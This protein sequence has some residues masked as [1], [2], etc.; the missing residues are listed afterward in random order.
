MLRVAR[1]LGPSSRRRAERYVQGSAEALPLPDGSASVLWSVATVHHWRDLAAGLAEVR[2]VLRPS[3]RFL[4]IERRVTPG[5]TGHASHGWTDEQVERFADECRGA[6][7]VD[8]GI[9]T[10]RTRRRDVVAVLAR[11]PRPASR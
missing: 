1:L 4:A 10:H 5:A 9:S 6:G 11:V 8:I 7:F 2:R 3:R